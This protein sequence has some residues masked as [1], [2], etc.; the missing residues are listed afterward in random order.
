MNLTQILEA[1]IFVSAQPVKKSEIIEILKKE[2]DEEGEIPQEADVV[3]ALDNLLKKYEADH[4]PFEVRKVAKGYQ[5]FTKQPYYPYVK[6]AALDRN[7]KRLTRAALETLSIM[8]YRQPV[9]KAEVEFIRGVNC[10]YAVQK[11]LEKKL[12]EIS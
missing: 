9:T 7:Q 12:V 5:F 1:V 8:A 10:D 4:Y 2:A 6:H 11:L 3:E